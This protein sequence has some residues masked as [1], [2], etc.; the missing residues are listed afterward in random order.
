M[1]LLLGLARWCRVLHTVPGVRQQYGSC[2]AFLMVIDVAGCCVQYLGYVSNRALAQPC[3][4][5]LGVA[6]C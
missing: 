3:F 5:V 1:R 6:G 4:M 2:S